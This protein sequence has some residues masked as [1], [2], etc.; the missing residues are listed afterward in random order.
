M[1]STLIITKQIIKHNSC[2]EYYK[3]F[4]YCKVDRQGIVVI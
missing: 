3:K 2:D 1:L 4:K